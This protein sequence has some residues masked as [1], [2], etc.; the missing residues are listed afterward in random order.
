MFGP[1]GHAYVYFIYGMHF[2]VN[3]VCGLEGTATAVLL[4]A[5]RVTE[6]ARSRPGG[7]SRGRRRPPGRWPTGTW[8][9][10]RPG[11]ARPS[12]IGRA[13]DGAD[14]CDAASPLR[15]RAD[16][17]P[18]PAWAAGVPRQVSQGPRVGVAAPPTGPGGSG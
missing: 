17:G 10:A 18:A 16:R 8:P 12:A 13:Q 15:V 3:L 11:C 6:G 5:G 2:C 9:A 4:R 1:P 7:G 14:V